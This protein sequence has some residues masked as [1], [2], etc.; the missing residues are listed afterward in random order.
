MQIKVSSINQYATLQHIHFKHK[1]QLHATYL[2]FYCLFT[3]I[4]I[5]GRR[6]LNM[7]FQTA[8]SGNFVI[9]LISIVIRPISE[10]EQERGRRHFCYNCQM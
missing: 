9:K 7:I 8:I 6:S 5:I 4:T 1:L 2:F 3:I 10:N